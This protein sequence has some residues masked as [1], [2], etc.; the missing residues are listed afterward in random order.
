MLNRQVSE[1]SAQL[2]PTAIARTSL[3]V[4]TTIGNG[5]A[6]SGA[7]NSQ[8]FPGGS[9]ITP[10]AWTAAS[11]GFKVCSTPD[12]TFVPLRD[13]IG[14]LVQITGVVI[15]AAAAYPLPDELFGCLYFKLWSCTAAGVDTN[16]GADRVLT[17]VLK[18]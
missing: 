3:A 6:L 2:T 5:T 8:L 15:D 12:G 18:G 14:A 10:A 16:Q 9:I 7:I 4:D 1:L 11:I 13:Q 17:V